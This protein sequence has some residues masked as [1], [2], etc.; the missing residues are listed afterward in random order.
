MLLPPKLFV[1]AAKKNIFAFERALSRRCL[2]TPDH[3]PCKSGP[4]R[5]LTRHVSRDTCQPCLLHS[6]T[7][8]LSS[9]FVTP[10]AAIGPHPS[11]YTAYLCLH[12]IPLSCRTQTPHIAAIIQYVSHTNDALTEAASLHLP[13]YGRGLDTKTVAELWAA[14]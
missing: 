12:Q 14:L 2:W 8:A 6:R 13:V 4:D 5:L 11:I 1:F 10:L 3:G 9:P 7:L